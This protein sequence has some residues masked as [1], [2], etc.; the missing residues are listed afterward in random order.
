[1]A[2]A[3]MTIHYTGHVFVDDEKNMVKTIQERWKKKQ[4]HYVV[5]IFRITICNYVEIASMEHLAQIFNIANFKPH[6]MYL[7]MEY[8]TMD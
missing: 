5:H 4:C 8:A 6:S 2:I 3:T 1:M 7:S